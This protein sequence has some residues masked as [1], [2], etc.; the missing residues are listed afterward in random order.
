M[1]VRVRTAGICGSDLHNWYGRAREELAGT[2]GDAV[3]PADGSRQALQWLGELQG[4]ATL[5]IAEGVG[6]ELH[7][8]LIECALHRLR[9]HIPMR[10]WRAALGAVPARSSA[11]SH[12]SSPGAAPGAATH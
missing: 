7:L 12:A 4:D 8:A 10:T 9:S 2:G 5:D 1:A 6:H 11:G 3:I